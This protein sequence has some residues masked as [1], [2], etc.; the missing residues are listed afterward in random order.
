MTGDTVTGVATGE[1]VTGAVVFVT[2]IG[3]LVTG[4]V[5]LV[6]IGSAGRLEGLGVGAGTTGRGEGIANC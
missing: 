3:A 6:S 1:P 4:V 5:V 2:G